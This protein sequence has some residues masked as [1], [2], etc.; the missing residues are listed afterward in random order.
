MTTLDAGVIV[1]TLIFLIRGLMIG[2]VRQIASLSALSIG[3]IAA[4]HYYGRFSHLLKGYINE[5]QLTF[6]LTYALVFIISYV[7]IILAGIA[8]KK[9]MQIS[10]L[11]WFDRT[12]GGVFG[13][14]K[15]LFLNTL[16]FMF[17]SWIL[18][19]SSPLIQRSFFSKYLSQSAHI[20]TRLIND[21]E[22]R[23]HLNPKQP[24]IS[25]FLH[26]PVKFLKIGEGHPQ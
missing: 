25:A 8:L 13:F 14:A 19:S 15:A 9:V 24:A 6:I 23:G 10:F 11:G 17:L 7:G 5:P 4:G 3:F 22:L 21:E 18:S 1:I 2:F 20:L 12:M 26:D 16:I